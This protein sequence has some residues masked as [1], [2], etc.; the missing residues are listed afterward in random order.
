MVIKDYENLMH[1]KILVFPVRIGHVYS[2]SLYYFLNWCVFFF[3]FLS[4]FVNII[5]GFHLFFFFVP[6]T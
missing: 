1:F 5:F 3:I 2:F 6:S 4:T